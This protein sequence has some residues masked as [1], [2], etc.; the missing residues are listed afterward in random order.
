M[1]YWNKIDPKNLPKLTKGDREFVEVLTYST[2]RHSVLR[3]LMEGLG[4]SNGL[5]MFVSADEVI[6]DVTGNV[7]GKKDCWDIHR[8]RDGYDA[9][10]SVYL[11]MYPPEDMTWEGWGIT[12]WCYLPDKLPDTGQTELNLWS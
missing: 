3:K 10:K 12:H 1:L 6:D 11:N 9:T 7:T 8:P 5:H 2:D 4:A